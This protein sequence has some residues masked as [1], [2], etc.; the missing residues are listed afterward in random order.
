MPRQVGTDTNWKS[1]AAGEVHSL[2]IKTDGSLYAFG[3][4]S[5]GQLGY[6]EALCSNTSL[7]PPPDML[8][9]PDKNVPVRVCSG[10][11]SYA[12]SP[13]I[14]QCTANDANWA[15]IYAGES[16]SVG[17]KTDGSM[18]A[19]GY[20]GNGQL[21]LGTVPP[22]QVATPT[23]VGAD[24]NWKDVRAG[25]Y[26]TI[27]IKNDG[28]LWGAGFN[29]FG[30]LGS[31]NYQSS[32]TFIQI[33]NGTNWANIA[34]AGYHSIGLTS[35]PSD[36][37]TW[38][39][40]TFGE[41]GNGNYNTFNT[42]QKI[43]FPKF[44]ISPSRVINFGVVNVPLETN[45]EEFII[46][47]VGFSP[48]QISNISVQGDLDSFNLV[49]NNC[50]GASL[51]YNQLCHIKYTFKPLN[52]GEKVLNIVVNSND[53]RE[54]TLYLQFKGTGRTTLS[55]SKSGYGSGVVT[56]FPVGINCGT[57]CSFS[58]DTLQTITL[59]PSA[60]QGSQFTGWSVACSGLSNCEIST[61]NNISVVANFKEVTA[62]TGTIVINNGNK[63]TQSQTIT[64]NLSCFDTGS[65]CASM[66][67]S[68][69]GINWSLF[70]SYSTSKQYTFQNNT[71]GEK[72]VFV[73]FKD[74]DGNLSLPYS[75]NIIYDKT[76]PT[77]SYYPQ[78]G[79]YNA[80]QLITLYANESGKIYYS[81][82]GSEPT[83]IYT[84]AIEINTTTTL[85]F[86]AQDE[87]GNKETTRSIAYTIDTTPPV[88][89]FSINNDAP[90]TNSRDVT[91]TISCT[92]NES[93]CTMMMFSEDGSLWSNPEAFAST[94]NFSISSS[95]DGP[96]TIYISV[97]NGA[98]L[99]SS[100]INKNIRLDT[101]PP[102]TTASPAGG[103][104]NTTQIITLTTSENAVIYY[105]QDGSSPTTFSPKYT[106][107]IEIS[108]TTTLKYFAVD[109][110]GN[111]ESINTSTYTIDTQTPQGTV[112][113]NNGLLDTNNRSVILTFNVSGLSNITE[114][115]VTNDSEPSDNTTNVY[116]YP[117]NNT[118]PWQLST[119]DGLKVV[120]VRFKNQAGTWSNIT[121]DTIILDTTNPVINT[122]KLSGTYNSPINVELTCNDGNGAGCSSI[123]YTL[124]GTD[125]NDSSPTYSAPIAIT[126]S[127][128]LKV[129]GKDLV[130]NYSQIYTYTYTI[131]TTIPT[132]TITINNGAVYTNSVYA[133]LTLYGS[134]SNSQT[135]MQFS[136]DGTNWTPEESYNTTKIFQ[137]SPPDGQKT[138]CVRYSDIASNWSAP[139]CDTIILDQTAPQSTISPA[140]GLFNSPQNITITTNEPATICYTTDGSDPIYSN[141][142]TC[143]QGTSTNFSFS[144][145][146]TIKFLA[147]DMAG[148]YETMKS[149]S[150]TIDTTPPTGT[151]T[152]N[153][154]AVATNNQTVTLTITASDANGVSKMQFSNDGNNWSAPE[155]FASSKQWLLTQ[156]DGEKTVY[157]RFIDN[158]GNISKPIKNSI[159]FDTTPPEIN[160]SIPPGT[161]FNAFNLE[162]IT[163]ELATIFYSTDNGQTYKQ[164]SEA[165]P[166]TKDTT[167]TLYATDLAGN[168]SSPFA[169]SYSIDF[170]PPLNV[171]VNNN[172][173]YTNN[174]L[175]KINFSFTKPTLAEG[176]IPY[177]MSFSNDG[178]NFSPE[179][180]FDLNY[181][182]TSFLLDDTTDGKKNIYIRFKDFY[183]NISKSYIPNITL[184]SITLDRIKPE[185]TITPLPGV[186]TTVP[187]SITLT[188]K[189]TSDKIYYSF[190]KDSAK[191]LY[192]QPIV[193]TSTTTIYYYGIDLAGNI[194]DEKTATYIVNIK[195]NLTFLI[196]NGEEKTN[197]TDVLLTI[198]AQDPSKI[199][200]VQFSND[201]TVWSVFN[202]FSLGAN[203]PWTL[204][205]VNGK[206]T[207]YLRIKDLFGNVSDIYE[208]SIILDNTA[209]K[210]SVNKASGTYYSKLLVLLKTDEPATIY[211]TTDGTS[212]TELSQYCS[213]ADP[214]MDVCQVIIDKTST[215]KY[216]AIDGLNNKSEASQSDYIIIPT[217]TLTLLGD[218]GVKRDDSNSATN[219][220][221][222]VTN[223][224]RV[225]FEYTFAL[226]VKDGGG[227]PKSVKIFIS[228]RNNPTLQDFTPYSLS[229]S[230]DY[231]NGANCEFKTKLNSPY[232]KYY[233]E[234]T[235]SDGNT[236]KQ[237]TDKDYF[238]GPSNLPLNGYNILSIPRNLTQKTK[239]ELF[240]TLPVYKWVSEGLTTSKIRGHFELL[241][242]TD[243]ILAG[244]AYFVYND[245]KSDWTTYLNA[246]QLPNTSQNS[247]TVSLKPGW[248]LISNPYIG[249]I[250]IKDIKITNMKT[251]QS[252]SWI[253][254][255][256]EKLIYNAAYFYKGS[257]WGGLYDF[258]TVG[259]K[260]GML[261]P[262]LG[263]W[264]YL[265]SN[266]DGFVLE[267]YQPIN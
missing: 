266:D 74:N 137:L 167:I 227:A 11:I 19:F 68:E 41:L 57:I 99:W 37:F 150:F 184:A 141:S 30:Q 101:T 231:S 166:I 219:N 198:N 54:K 117:I 80:P 16:H 249:N 20:N 262:W 127:K 15:K 65:G 253:D 151:F 86:Y 204:S 104:Y 250:K 138:V 3:N 180:P 192:T 226:L 260:D 28:S 120:Y 129:R 79:L 218:N 115:Q 14:H 114:F 69:D 193:I 119:G 64:L 17:I 44:S 62:P 144:N 128:T 195:P 163:N 90:L 131:D 241:N 258:E 259:I 29:T 153:N 85:K 234:V 100:P 210:V 158:A 109:S 189:E 26:H 251:K 32:N 40:N 186:I 207:V 159:I 42:P 248:N 243:T 121:S 217:D 205:S 67:F 237:P 196:N 81:T 230:G 107:P 174:P 23:K 12:Q 113:I 7:C 214:Y 24:V 229:C 246:T 124:D 8:I 61:A 139:I 161:V 238:D 225:D 223:K 18:W 201:K 39:R 162:L 63:F 149:A 263:Y 265:N 97:K 96:K 172:N 148:N 168:S 125:P 25:A 220:I 46:K 118:Y 132:G 6:E 187:I 48:L 200:A 176:E 22:V 77:T 179:E 134:K 94:K 76:P 123:F 212:P 244:E 59:Y 72:N 73:R 116:T 152:I 91:L 47:N 169:L 256:K 70:E 221:D 93:G 254:A 92:D 4:N 242:S 10:S 261:I 83:N 209:P 202:N 171:V 133:S 215:L 182:E 84:G 165:L 75:D 35:S 185:T 71:E 235:L 255:A 135:K 211:Y 126:Q 178:I 58:Y 102:V 208:S 9:F 51:G 31:G 1:V 175:I 122:S 111:Q 2:A 199:S 142:K 112:T 27:A 130:G 78:G 108:S 52:V 170:Q 183:G 191:I 98:G 147:Y 146:A 5:N 228:D 82:D 267:F 222:P 206:K 257:D 143:T 43:S 136:T 252:Y 188:P 240:G 56:S 216:F 88:V 177:F 89:N 233:F 232:T 164:Y 105:T 106:S 50:N 194:E 190:S 224:P 213:I 236:I 247:I 245:N 156:G 33:G 13:Y 38:G 264:F 157:A 45:P 110:A 154:G 55:V 66:Q 203:F 49:E 53:Q 34:A 173:L 145:T 87:A 21:G 181:T 103:T 197:K 36:L 155:A 239:E 160:P 60:D 95:G 140:G